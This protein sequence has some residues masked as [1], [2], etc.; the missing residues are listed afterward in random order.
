MITTE[1]AK[2]I[3]NHATRKSAPKQIYNNLYKM[4][5]QSRLYACSLVIDYGSFASIDSL[6]DMYRLATASF[7]QYA[8]SVSAA[9]L[10]ADYDATMAR[11]VDIV[12]GL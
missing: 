11:L 2:R 5:K 9:E 3:I 4:D 7:K 10:D 6:G 1:T 8:E 12:S